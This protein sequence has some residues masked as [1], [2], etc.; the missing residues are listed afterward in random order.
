VSGV[1][2]IE[3][4]FDPFDAAI[5]AIEAVREIGVL[6]FE[7]TKARLHLAH[8]VAKAIDGTT[9]VPQMLQDDIVRFGHVYFH[10]ILVIS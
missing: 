10:S 4:A 9:D 2:Q 8:I 7:N 3:T 6:T 1:S 5:D